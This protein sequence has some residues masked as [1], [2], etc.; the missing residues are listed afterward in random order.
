MSRQVDYIPEVHGP[1]MVIAVTHEGEFVFA[2]YDT[3]AS[4]D[5]A[6]SDANAELIDDV[7]MVCNGAEHTV[8]FADDVIKFLKRDE[9][10]DETAASQV[11]S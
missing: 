1:Y 3:K 9:E 6:F 2:R 8:N 5:K 10:I 7:E 4:R 11:R